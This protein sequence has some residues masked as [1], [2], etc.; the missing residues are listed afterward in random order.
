MIGD[1]DC[2][3][4]P[5]G[6]TL[7][8]ISGSCYLPHPDKEETGGEDAHFICSEE[9]AIGVADGVGGW[10][11]LGVNAGYYS[12]ELMSKSVEAIQ[13][14]PKGSIDPARVLEK[15]HSST[16]ARGSSTACIIAL[17]DQV[18][19]S[20][21]LSC[22]DYCCSFC[23]ITLTYIA[24]VL[25]LSSLV[26][27]SLFFLYIVSIFFLLSNGLEVI[28][29]T[30]AA[31]FIHYSIHLSKNHIETWKMSQQYIGFPIIFIVLL[32]T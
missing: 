11:D 16:K 27:A 3:K 25:N 6:K 5:S 1:V 13:E 21:V 32:I 8:L 7:K 10:A 12:R 23:A 29:L 26:I 20:S 4:T 24:L 15:A 2:R 30:L 17:T 28:C 18:N 9:Q 14:E 19:F 31:Y 22:L